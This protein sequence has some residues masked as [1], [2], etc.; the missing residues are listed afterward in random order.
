M[1]AVMS[2]DSKA[3]G[4]ARRWWTEAEDHILR[5]EVLG[6]RMFSADPRDIANFWRT[7]QSGFISDWHQIAS[8]LPDR[9]NK[10]CR[11]RWNKISSD[12]KKGAWDSAEDR[13]LRSAVN[14]YGLCW[15]E[16]AK[17]VGT[18]HADQCAK[19]WQHALDPNIM[20]REWEQDEDERLLR[21]VESQGRVWSRLAEKEFPNRSAT[22]IK[23]R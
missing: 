2:I 4:R 3:P 21:A 16:V 13:R 17:E 19:R 22:D 18:R 15:T 11:K 14:R 9:S 1:P 8:S 20:H 5:R 23:N 7:V 6:Q 10:D 12:V